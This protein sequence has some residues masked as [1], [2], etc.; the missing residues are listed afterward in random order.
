MYLISYLKLLEDFTHYFPEDLMTP[1][2]FTTKIVI[3]F[4][5]MAYQDINTPNSG[6]G[7]LVSN[8]SIRVVP[9]IWDYFVTSY[10][11]VWLHLQ[12]LQ[13][14]LFLGQPLPPTPW[15]VRSSRMVVPHWCLRRCRG[16]VPLFR[17]WWRWETDPGGCWATSSSRDIF[18]SPLLK[19]S[20]LVGG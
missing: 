19:Q 2:S 13:N 1:W 18:V 5:F 8:L 3:H 4:S 12:P 16:M 14:S 15:N 17:S 11:G 9:T 10:L 20:L 6:G 7:S